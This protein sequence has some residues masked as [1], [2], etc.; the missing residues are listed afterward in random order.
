MQELIGT[1]KMMPYS[2]E[3]KYWLPCDGRKVLI[4]SYT[5]LFSIIGTKFGGDGQTHFT[6]PNFSEKAAGMAG[7]GN[8]ARGISTRKVGEVDGVS[9]VSLGIYNLP[10]HNHFV[11]ATIDTATDE[12]PSEQVTFAM[13]MIKDPVS[14]VDVLNFAY[15]L[16]PPTL[17][18]PKDTV[19]STGDSLPHNNMQPY[20]AMQF[21]ICFHGIYPSKD[22]VPRPDK[23][24]EYLGSIKYFAGNFEPYGWKF[25]MGQL[26]QIRRDAALFRLIGTTYGGDGNVTF[27]LPN[28]QGQVAVG[29][30]EA[31][32]LKLELGAKGGEEK[33]SLRTNH[34][35]VHNHKFR[36][37]DVDAEQF[38][39]TDK[40]YVAS[41]NVPAGRDTNKGKTF[42]KAGKTPMAQDMIDYSGNGIPHD[43]MMP[44]L[45]L[46]AMICVEGVFPPPNP[47]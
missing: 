22:Y 1:I 6:L 15:S 32:F 24:E 34:L 44:T 18:L 27:A 17:K 39:P 26:M 9:E 3:L 43:N 4:S 19:S 38:M 30:G 10:E 46:Y 40:T 11:N 2:K 41:S 35:P 16:K 29:A 45:F 7:D 13:P 33:V 36:S 14:Q 37:T 42:A 12:A 20:T 47:S 31:E 8:G 25:C 23:R 21:M 28:L 5:E